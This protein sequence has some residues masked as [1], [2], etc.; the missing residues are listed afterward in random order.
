M[1]AT[2]GVTV[3][4]RRGQ[5]LRAAWA[6]WR[7]DVA[8]AWRA[9]WASRLLVWASGL[10]AIAIWGIHR[11]HEHAFDRR[12]LA[13]PFGDVLNTLVAPAARWDAYWYLDIAH[14][15]YHESLNRP[16]FF[17][18]YPMSIKAIAW[19]TGEP[20]LVGLLL[21]FIC[22]WV[23]L[24]AFHR[25]A[26]LE[27]GPDAA[28]WAVWG[29][30]LFPGSLWFSAVYSESLFLM[31]SV[32]AVLCA[33]R[34][35]FA[36]AGVLGALGSATRSAGLLLMLPLALLWWDAYRGARPPRARP[37]PLS[38]GWVLLVPLGLVAYCG[39]LA[40]DGMS[41]H[42]PFAAQ[43]VWNR[44]FK[45]P[46]AGIN[47][48]ATA[49]FDGLRQIIHGSPTPVY[50]ERAAGDSIAVGRHDV[51]LFLCLVIAVPALV[52]AFRRLPLAHGAYA[53]CALLLPLSYP[54]APQPL[55]SLPRFE[56]VLYPLFLWLGW[57][58]ARGGAVRRAIVFG[59]FAFFLAACSA[60]FST[61]HWVA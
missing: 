21:S 28:R 51:A 54:V 7:P 3:Q 2:V 39:Y 19:V 15:G 52:G 42:A 1:C 6:S 32:G 48:G 57:W 46:F 50:W 35:R 13:R 24:A 30:V 45:G 26:A 17:P 33:R 38:L 18:L 49:A 5:R 22:F 14:R 31:V 44:S 10:G 56:A 36:W 58:L 20:L 4:K 37:S 9:L 8:I 29:L 60:L 61:W 40:A 27:L 59:V 47:Q 43:D 41:W 25:L 55:M 11:T 53:L 16:A 12:G 23:G 34:E